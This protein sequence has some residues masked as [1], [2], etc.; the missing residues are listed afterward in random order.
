MKKY[1]RLFMNNSLGLQGILY[2]EEFPV[3][4]S[5]QALS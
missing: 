3:G 1:G 4:S 5:L 2:R